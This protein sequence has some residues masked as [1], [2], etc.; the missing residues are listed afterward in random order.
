VLCIVFIVPIVFDTYYKS[1]YDF[2]PKHHKQ[3]FTDILTQPVLGI[4]FEQQHVESDSHWHC[5]FNHNTVSCRLLQNKTRSSK[6]A[7]RSMTTIV[8]DCLITCLNVVILHLHG[9]ETYAT[10]NDS[11]FNKSHLDKSL[12]TM[13]MTLYFAICHFSCPDLV[14]KTLLH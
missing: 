11:R 14:F 10:L 13:Q 9:Y 5:R 7:T 1:I 6:V 4:E 2:G 8:H 3:S 12:H